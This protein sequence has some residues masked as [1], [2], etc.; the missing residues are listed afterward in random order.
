MY[1]NAFTDLHYFIFTSGVPPLLYYSHIPVALTS[2]LLGVFVFLKDR[3]A[4]LNKILFGISA[5]FSLWVVGDLVVWLSP[6]SRVVMFFWSFFGLV[7]TLITVLCVYFVYVFIKERDIYFV[8]KILW[9]ATLLPIIV[10]TPTV[11][12]LSG[13]DLSICGANES[14]FVI[15]Y[16]FFYGV[17]AFLWILGMGVY[18][19]RKT[20][21][22][23]RRK[24]VLLVVG[25]EAFLLSFF[26]A[27]F[28][29]SYLT[30]QGLIS[31]FGL[32]QYGLFG[33]VIFIGLLTYLITKYKAFNI[34]LIAVQALVVSILVLTGSEFFF[35]QSDINRVLTAITLIITA[36]IGINLIR[37]VKREIQMREDIESL[38][39]ELEATNERQETLMRFITHEVKGYLTKDQG[40]FAALVDGDFG[41]LSDGLKPFVTQALAQTRL[42]V[43]S[44]MNILKAANLKKGTTAYQL[45]PFDLAALAAD[46]VEKAKPAAEAKKLALSYVADPAGA[47]YTMTGDQKEV[48]EHVLRN[49]IENSLNYTLAGSIEVSLK[50]LEGKLIFAVKDTGVGITAED[51]ARLFTEGGHGKDSQ[52]VNVHSTGYGLYIAKT[53]VEAHHGTIRAESEGAGKGSTFTVEFPV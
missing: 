5:L 49:L 52:S 15:Y 10:L 50:K 33:M 48:G 46:V 20:A 16:K 4:L 27:T 19:Y 39:R 17:F 28:I 7:F 31:D 3:S 6:D 35:I 12:N 43:E 21:Q 36:G 2:L 30:S 32:E 24:V 23:S 34:K 26:T 11:Y 44:V 8:Q 41:A 40:A 29:T 37:S 1:C 51:K 42:G 38:A 53:I 18:N 9:L 14:A 13:F 45:A 25:V 22:E 47:P